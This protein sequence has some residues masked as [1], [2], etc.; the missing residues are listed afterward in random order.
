[1]SA[2]E[3][4]AEVARRHAGAQEFLR[5]RDMAFRQLDEL[6]DKLAA[7]EDEL[8]TMSNALSLK[9]AQRLLDDNR[10]HREREGK[11]AVIARQ[12]QREGLH[13]PHPTENP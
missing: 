4:R 6:R 13:F 8:R 3:L 7:S 9:E 2:D 12:I 10:A 1:M 11:R 5:V